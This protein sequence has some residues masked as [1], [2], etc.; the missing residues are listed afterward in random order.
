MKEN[1]F[2]STPFHEIQIQIIRLILLDMMN[3][4]QYFAAVN[5]SRKQKKEDKG[6]EEYPEK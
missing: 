5:K 1:A 4:L 6:D 3:I 2:H